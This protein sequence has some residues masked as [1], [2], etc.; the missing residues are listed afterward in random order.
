MAVEPLSILLEME[1]NSNFLTILDMV[2]LSKASGSTMNV[3]KW[4]NLTNC[5]TCNITAGPIL[6]NFQCCT[7][8]L[9]KH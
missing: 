4:R 3:A 9:K 7:L 8:D 2:I 6:R 1:V 5:A